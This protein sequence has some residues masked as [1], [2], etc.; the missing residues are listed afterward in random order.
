MVW[1]YKI[2]I[3][4]DYKLKCKSQSYKPKIDN[5]GANLDYFGHGG[6]FLDTH[7]TKTP[8][9]KKLTRWTSFKL[10][11]IYSMKYNIKIVKRKPANTN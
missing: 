4:V 10:K 1:V 8:P 11:I 7:K 2:W 9:I 3:K 5:I 6:D